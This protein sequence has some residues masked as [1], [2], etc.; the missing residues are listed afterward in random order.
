MYHLIKEIIT[1]YSQ[2][3][4]DPYYQDEVTQHLNDEN[5]YRCPVCGKIVHAKDT[6]IHVDETRQSVIHSDRIIR[7]YGGIE[8]LVCRECEIYMQKNKKKVKAIAWIIIA[9]LYGLGA[10]LMWN[11]YVKPIAIIIMLFTAYQCLRTVTGSHGYYEFI[12]NMFG[13]RWKLDQ[14]DTEIN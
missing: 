14:E 12:G 7:A 8:Y 10:Y 11:D 2:I 6:I 5:P 9:L 4:I 1:M 3:I 13:L